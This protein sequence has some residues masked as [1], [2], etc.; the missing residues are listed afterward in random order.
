MIIKF[1]GK[2]KRYTSNNAAY[3]GMKYYYTNKINK[4][5]FFLLV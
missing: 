5:S 1:H 2:A 3:G 4:Q